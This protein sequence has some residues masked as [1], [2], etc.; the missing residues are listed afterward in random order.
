MGNKE[1]FLQGSNLGARRARNVGGD[2]TP[3]TKPNSMSNLESIH[4]TLNNISSTDQR[5]TDFLNAINSMDL[6]NNDEVNETPI[7]NP[8]IDA[9]NNDLF[10]VF[11]NED[12][13]NNDYQTT[14]ETTNQYQSYNQYRE[15]NTYDEEDQI[16]E[17]EEAFDDEDNGYEE[18]I[19][20]TGYEEEINIPAPRIRTVPAPRSVARPA[21]TPTPTPEPEPKT[22]YRRRTKAEIEKAKA[23]KVAAEAAKKA[24]AEAAKKAA[25]E[26]AAREAE[27]ANAAAAAQ[28]AQAM[29]NAAATANNDDDNNVDL[30]TKTAM[31]CFKFIAREILDDIANDGK[32]TIFTPEMVKSMCANAVV[33]EVSEDP[34]FIALIKEYINNKYKHEHYGDEITTLV[35]RCLIG[36]IDN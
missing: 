7:T 36:K 11:D 31:S 26:K 9:N 30:Y 19:G 3:P 18:T 28:A 20:G 1:K 21:L 5:N 23:E 33:D 27:A 13:E 15:S 12:N 4:N 35:L 14:A 32:S 6:S 22:H 24:A 25:A 8:F 29:A 2:I 16:E 34:L 17:N 10:S